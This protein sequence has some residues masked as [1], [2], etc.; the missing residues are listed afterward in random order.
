VEAVEPATIGDELRPLFLEHF[1]DRL[2]RTLGMGV[3]LRPHQAPI[4][5]PGVKFVVAWEPGFWDEEALADEPDLVLDLP[6]LPARRRR[7]GDRLDQMMRAHLNKAAIVLP[8]LAD[9]HRIDRRFHVVI[10]SARARALEEGEGAIVRVEHHL[11]ALARIGAHEHHPTV[12]EP[13]M[14]D[15]QSR[16]HAADQSDLVTPIELVG[17][18]RSE[19]QRNVGVRRGARALLP[20]GDRIAPDCRV[21]AS[22]SKSAQIL[23]NPDQRQTLASE[24]TVV[25]IKQGLK[26]L[27]P[28]TNPWQRLLRA[29]VVKL[30]GV[31]PDDLPDHF[32]R[33]MQVP[34]DLLDR[35][36]LRKIGPPY[37]RDRFHNKHSNPALLSSEGQCEPGAARVPIG[38]KSAP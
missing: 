3:G 22:I 12:A 34:A 24:P 1:P 38:C 20:P 14:G 33:N 35:L 26:L 29:L 10:D 5:Q 27:P 18:A 9:E 17:L 37:L 36:P 15:L 16:R 2:F 19:A 11:L 31:R 28:G 23:E 6:F 4:E 21:T 25:L 13:D 8:S 32:P 30:G 7:A